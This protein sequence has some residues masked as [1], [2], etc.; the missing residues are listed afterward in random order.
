ML[1]QLKDIG[2]GR[3]QNYNMIR[4]STNHKQCK[5]PNHPKQELALDLN[6]WS[7]TYRWLPQTDR[8]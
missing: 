8:V 7:A 5:V 4:T 1:L 2:C 6:E 3:T